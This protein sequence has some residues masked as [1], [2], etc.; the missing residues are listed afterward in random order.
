MESEDKEEMQQVFKRLQRE[1][2]HHRIISQTLERLLYYNQQC[3]FTSS[4]Y[5]IYRMRHFANANKS[6]QQKLSR[7]YRQVRLTAVKITKARNLKLLCQYFQEASLVEGVT[8]LMMDH[9]I[10]WFA[11]DYPEYKKHGLNWEH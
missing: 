10:D 5:L 4:S 11:S 3:T 8:M 2:R 6:E 9:I 7:K 1:V